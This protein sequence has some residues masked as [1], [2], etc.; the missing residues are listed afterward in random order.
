MAQTTQC[1]GT[2]AGSVERIVEMSG[3][4]VFELGQLQETRGPPLNPGTQYRGGRADLIDQSRPADQKREDVL[5]IMTVE[6]VIHAAVTKGGE[7]EPEKSRSAC[8]PNA[9]SA[10]EREFDRRLDCEGVQLLTRG[11][12]VRSRRKEIEE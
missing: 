8:V 10:R 9:F 6:R 4:Q 1:E 5:Q 11:A 7:F 2:R 3:D 12:K